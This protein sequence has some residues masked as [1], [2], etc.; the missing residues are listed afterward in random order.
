MK[1]LFP[2]G[3]W[4]LCPPKFFDVEYEI[5]PW[6]DVNRAPAATLAANQWKNLHHRLI[7]LGAYVEYIEATKGNPDLVF[8]A[9]AGLVKGDKFVLSKFK[10]PERQGEEPLFKD[11]FAKRGYEVIELKSDGYFEGEGDALFAG[12]TLFCGFGFRSDAEV[13]KEVADA[14]DVKNTV[15]CELIDSRFYHL[16]TCFCPLNENQAIY[17]KDAF[18]PASIAEMEKHIE[19]FA[20]DEQDAKRFVCNAVVLG[21]Q[22]VL[23]A[24]CESTYDL[25]ASLGYESSDVILKEFLKGGGSAKCLSLRIDR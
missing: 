18:S 8:T 7:R 9:N 19:L 1:M 25:L 15:L 5:N 3:T 10:H 13:Y 20:V 17:H 16:D 12:D 24:E 21:K 23:P 22:V 2:H 14:L 4:L 11:W 6:M